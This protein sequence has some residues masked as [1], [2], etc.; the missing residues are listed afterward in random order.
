MSTTGGKASKA[1]KRTAATKGANKTNAQLSDAAEKRVRAAAERKRQREAQR[2]AQARAEALEVIRT[3]PSAYEAALMYF[4]DFIPHDLLGLT[5]GTEE[6]EAAADALLRRH[7]VKRPPRREPYVESFDERAERRRA[8]LPPAPAAAAAVL[9][10]PKRERT[11]LRASS[12]FQ[13]AEADA[14]NRAAY[15]IFRYAHSN[16]SPHAA[17]DLFDRALA[18]GAY[19]D[20]NTG[21]VRCNHDR[22]N[23][24]P[25]C[26]ACTGEYD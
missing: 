3:H 6:A 16:L 4:L 15:N 26:P 2:L 5:P 17:D 1:K 12:Y 8:A 19:V 9:S 18:A 7:G 25:A 14:A 22:R 13:S 20:P 21:A 11:Y 10:P 23:T 24:N